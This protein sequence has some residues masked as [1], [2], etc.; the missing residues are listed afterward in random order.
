MLYHNHISFFTVFIFFENFLSTFFLFKRIE[1]K[2]ILK[3]F[4]ESI[5]LIHSYQNIRS[6]SK[7][8]A[9][10]A[11]FWSIYSMMLPHLYRI[12]PVAVKWREQSL[13]DPLTI[14]NA[15][16]IIEICIILFSLI[17]FSLIS[18]WPYLGASR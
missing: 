3:Y 11:I 8:T 15:T 2:I 16:P 12:T 6:Q 1:N 7:F 14:L 10:F 4:S 18:G 5:R 17:L 13:L 9:Y